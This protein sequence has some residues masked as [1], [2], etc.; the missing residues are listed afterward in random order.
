MLAAV[1]EGVGRHV[2][3]GHDVRLA[4]GVESLDGRVA[5]GGER[6]HGGDGGGG[7]G[8]GVEEVAGEDPRAGVVEGFVRN[9]SSQRR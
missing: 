3:D 4:R 8:Q 7:G 5:V 2:E 9:E 1:G 6:G